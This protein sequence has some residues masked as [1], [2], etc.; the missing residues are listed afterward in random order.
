M[1]WRS[2]NISQNC[3]SLWD[4]VDVRVMSYWLEMG[5]KESKGMVLP[6]LA[7][8]PGDVSSQL[9]NIKTIFHLERRCL[10]KDVGILCGYPKSVF[11]WKNFN[12][13]CEL[14]GKTSTQ[15]QSSDTS[16]ISGSEC[17]WTL[18]NRRS[19][20]RSVAGFS[21]YLSTR[22]KRLQRWYNLGST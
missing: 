22:R 8:Q 13:T 19:Q 5:S 11:L 15:N 12:K 10:Y 17:W 9:L 14:P 21:A 4:L 6:V 20:P 18:I 2:W 3:F 16:C 7:G 1:W